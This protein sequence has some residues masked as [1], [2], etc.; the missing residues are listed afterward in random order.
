[1]GATVLK[2]A[3]PTCNCEA[4]LNSPKDLRNKSSAYENA[5]YDTGAAASTQSD[6]PALPALPAPPAL[7]ASPSLPAP[8]AT[9]AEATYPYTATVEGQLTMVQGEVFTVLDASGN[10]W[11]LR[12]ASGQEGV[13]PSNYLTKKEQLAA[14]APAPAQLPPA[15]APA[16]AATPTPVVD[17]H[18]PF[19][20]A[21]D[22]NPFAEAVETD[23]STASK[24][25]HQSLFTSANRD[26][27]GLLTAKDAGALLAKSGLS[28][29]DLRTIWASAKAEGPGVCAA[30]K[31]DL[32]EF[33]IAAQKAEEAGG[34]FPT[35]PNT[36]EA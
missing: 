27:E 24:S 31:M 23:A 15:P 3:C 9:V 36:S 13:A 26:A 14:T 35:S 11:K 7:P 6:A 8:P 18:N 34:T 10:W 21:A 12:N 29:N 5:A 28:N 17:V 22:E 1:M 20:E 25:L 32:A 4:F 2:C 19:A 33:L 30:S 16:A